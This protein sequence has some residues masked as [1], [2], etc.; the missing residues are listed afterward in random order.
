MSLFDIEFGNWGS[1]VMVS[2]LALFVLMYLG[3][4]SGLGLIMLGALLFLLGIVL[5]Y[6]GVRIDNWM[7]HGGFRR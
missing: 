1:I 5:Y 4:M 6:I 3:G 2:L 7:R